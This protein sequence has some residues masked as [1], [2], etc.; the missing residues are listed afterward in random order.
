VFW[1]RDLI[2]IRAIRAHSR[3][4]RTFGAMFRESGSA[5]PTNHDAGL[6]PRP[7]S[8]TSSGT[9]VAALTRIVSD[10]HFGDHASRVARLEQ[11]RPLLEGVSHLILNGD[12]LDTRPGPLPAHTDECRAAVTSFFPANV[13]QSTFLSGNHDADFTP[14]HHV[15]LAHGDVFVT[16]GDIFFDD[17][18]PWSQDARLIS[19][20]IAEELR[21]IAPG[22]HHDME[23]RFSVI[24]RVAASIPQRHQSERNRLKFALLFI[25]DTI[26]PPTRMLR[27]LQAWRRAP[28]RAAEVSRRYRPGA[29]FVVCGHTHHPGV[30][31]DRAG[32]TVVNTG[33]FCP[34]LGGNVVDLSDGRLAVRRVEFRNG[35][36]RV[37]EQLAEF[38]LAPA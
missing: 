2:F 14:L 18:V 16:H 30:W 28:A 36:F 35:E 10:V 25:A 24:R 31:R 20:L 34:P 22:L 27:V 33:S 11:L 23:V 29:K 26:Y 9:T 6:T 15:D 21:G 17:I 5:R 19:R 1:D 32:V 7:A 4:A 13:P 3:A 8:T 38:P 12:T 37:T